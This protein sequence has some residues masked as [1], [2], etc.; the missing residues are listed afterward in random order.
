MYNKYDGQIEIITKIDEENFLLEI[1]DTGIGIEEEYQKKV[2]QK[3]YR[4][5]L[6]GSSENPGLGVGLYLTK[7]ITKL[8]GYEIQLISKFGM[9]T[10][11]ILSK[12]NTDALNEESR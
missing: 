7:E 9:G 10:K 6:S 8:L 11:L 12:D 4:V 1:S 2:F 5:D 3:F